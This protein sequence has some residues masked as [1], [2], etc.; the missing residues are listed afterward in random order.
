VSP[1]PAPAFPHQ[2]SAVLAHS[3]PSLTNP[4]PVN[5]DLDCFCLLAAG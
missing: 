5:P 3:S 2:S 1:S 4:S